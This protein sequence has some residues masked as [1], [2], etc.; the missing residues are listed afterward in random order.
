MGVKNLTYPLF[1][2]NYLLRPT[3]AGAEP[4]PARTELHDEINWC[5]LGGRIMLVI[6]ARE[7][8]LGYC[9]IELRAV[10]FVQSVSFNMVNRSLHLAGGRLYAY[11][12]PQKVAG[13]TSY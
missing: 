6:I 2:L 9:P 3:R 5:H 13:N 11:Y 1:A 10:E 4:G 7:R 8:L 12:Q